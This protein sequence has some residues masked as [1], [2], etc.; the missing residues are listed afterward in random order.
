MLNSTSSPPSSAYAKEKEDTPHH[1][2]LMWAKKPIEEK[3]E[4]KDARREI[5]SIHTEEAK[6]LVQ[7]LIKHNGLKVSP[8]V[9]SLN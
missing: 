8:V 9:H 4:K 6:K 1:T 5:K 2:G 7:N 3:T